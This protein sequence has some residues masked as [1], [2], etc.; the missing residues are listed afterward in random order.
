MIRYVLIAHSLIA[1]SLRDV[2]GLPGSKSIEAAWP[3]SKALQSNFQPKS[4]KMAALNIPF[5]QASKISKKAS[6]QPKGECR[7]RQLTPNHWAT[8]D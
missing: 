1:V 5:V 6:V 7:M 2:F 3:W 8:C 4:K